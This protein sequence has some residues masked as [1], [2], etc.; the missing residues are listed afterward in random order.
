M[1]I[2]DDSSD[3]H[4]DYKYKNIIQIIN[5][6]VQNVLDASSSLVLKKLGEKLHLS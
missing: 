6:L 2:L 5:D 4:P 3:H 1:E